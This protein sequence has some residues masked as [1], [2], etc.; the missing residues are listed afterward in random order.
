MNRK[1]EQDIFRKLKALTHAAILLR[2]A[3]ILGYIGETF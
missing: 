2:H 1:A 3:V